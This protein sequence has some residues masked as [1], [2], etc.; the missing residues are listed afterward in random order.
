[1]VYEHW[2]MAHGVDALYTDHKD[3]VRTLL[4]DRDWLF[5]HTGGGVL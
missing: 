3:A 1:M 2:L 4:D 5:L